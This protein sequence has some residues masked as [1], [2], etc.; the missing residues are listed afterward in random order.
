MRNVRARFH[1]VDDDD[2]GG[3]IVERSAEETLMGQGY[4]SA[5]PLHFLNLGRKLIPEPR[6]ARSRCV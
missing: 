3:R 1:A 2:P 4:P 6:G 5:I